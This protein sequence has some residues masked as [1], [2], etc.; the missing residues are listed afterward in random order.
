M[1]DNI[2]QQNSSKVCKCKR[3]DNRGILQNIKD[4]SEQWTFHRASQFYL[5]HYLVSVENIHYYFGE[6]VIGHYSLYP[7]ND[8]QQTDTKK[9]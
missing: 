4:K 9:F 6:C 1:I 5:E 7:E 3:A 2:E 8:K